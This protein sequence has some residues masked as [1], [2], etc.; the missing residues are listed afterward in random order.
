MPILRLFSTHGMFDLPHGD[1]DTVLDVLN[2]AQIAWASVAL[3]VKEVGDSGFRL[4]PCLGTKMSEFGRNTLVAAFLQRNID[5]TSYIHA[6]L[7][8]SDP[9]DGNG[10]VAEYL[11]R[12]LSQRSG[13]TILRRFSRAEC[14]QVVEENVSSMLDQYFE[15]SGSGVAKIVI[16]VSGGGDSNALISALEKYKSDKNI[17]IIPVIISGP[18]EWDAGISRAKDICDQ[19]SLKLN[20]VSELE[21]REILGAT[22]EGPD[23]I[24]RFG[25]QFPG[26]DYE[27]LGTLIIRRVLV[28]IAKLNNARHICT[29]INFEDLI[30]EYF[31]WNLRGGMPPELPVR[32]VD[33]V[34]LL[35]PLWKTPKKI[36]DG[37]YP[38]H[39]FANYE[40]RYPSFSP[41]RTL[42]YQLAY[43]LTSDFPGVGEKLL[44]S[45]AELS[46]RL[47]SPLVFDADLGFDTLGPIPMA[48]RLA[49]KRLL[50]AK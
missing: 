29:G 10:A 44:D 42:A 4:F 49:H 15:K 32:K 39:S 8:I 14:I 36:I 22:G 37:C 1:D 6:H 24:S 25:K 27:F 16:G 23:L 40:G 30:A 48:L 20:V 21:T 11:Y 7:K 5:P 2:S 43:V 28:H 3:Y 34:K 17:E 31:A 12:D 9:A 18:G 33:G 19:L 38:K 35:F 13:N 46:T 50:N 45:S 47:G 41:G 26:E